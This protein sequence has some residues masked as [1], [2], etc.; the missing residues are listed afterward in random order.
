VIASGARSPKRPRQTTLVLLMLSLLCS[1]LIIIVVSG[2]SKSSRSVA[3]TPAGSEGKPFG[4][5]MPRPAPAGWHQRT[6]SPGGA[7]LS[8]P[9]S[10]GPVRAD[11]G[12]LSE[13]VGASTARYEAYLNVTPRQRAE[14]PHKFAAFRLNHLADEDTDVHLDAAAER[15]AFLG[16]RGSCVMDDYRTR[17]GGNHYQEIACLVVGPRGAYVVVAA[18]RF[19]DWHR[20]STGFHETLDSFALARSPQKL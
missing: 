14:E 20:F 2:Q 10:F 6:T 11:A 12:A 15:L 17:V 5:L 16:G 3:S 19:G 1:A 9:A 4:W 13:A 7:V 18:A 8:Y